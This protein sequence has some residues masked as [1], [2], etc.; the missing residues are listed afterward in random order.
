WR[1]GRG[2]RT[3][4]AIVNANS[5]APLRLAEMTWEEVRDLDK[6]RAMAIL[7]SGAIEAHGPHLPLDT[8]IVIAEAM[9]ESAARI[10][11][12]RGQLPVFLPPFAF[13]A[14]PFA[15]A[16]AG[17]ISISPDA[18]AAMLMDLARSLD[19]AG[20][21]TMAIANAHL[22]PTHLG[23][24]HAAVDQARRELKLAIAFPDLTRKPWALRLTD[25]FKSGACHAGRF[26]TSIVMA[27]HPDR[28]RETLRLHLPENASSLS[29]AIREQK[30]TFLEAGGP[31]AYF[32]APAEASV[33]EGRQTIQILGEILAECVLEMPA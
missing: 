10:L 8:D 12:Q 4:A 20:F 28:V 5:A 1:A 32:G 11:S 3:M 18:S 27:R 7:P 13:T 17:T 9:A 21:R 30:K 19:R 15:G 24:L 33:E 2:R 6:S 29:V 31:L 26:E 22:D 14:A 23:S 25:E 16:F